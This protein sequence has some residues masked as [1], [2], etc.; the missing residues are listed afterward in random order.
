MF[1]PGRLSSIQAVRV[2]DVMRNAGSIGCSIEQLCPCDAPRQSTEP[3]KYHGQYVS[4]M[5]K[6]AQSF[7]A[8]GVISDNDK[9]DLVNAAAQS[10]CGY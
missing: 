8:D 6:A 4:C 1:V 10:S 3:W 9:S 7:A 2:A 5:T